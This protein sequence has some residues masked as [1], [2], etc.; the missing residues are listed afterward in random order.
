MGVPHYTTYS[1][2]EVAAQPGLAGYNLQSPLRY[3]ARNLLRVTLM[4]KHALVASLLIGFTLTSTLP[5][6]DHPFPQR[7]SAPDFPKGAEWLNTGGPL[8][9]QDLRGKF[10]LLDFW[11]YCCIN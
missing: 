3:L 9:K 2:R 1:G 5:A 8:R 6:D 11:T 7:I 10:V 4:F